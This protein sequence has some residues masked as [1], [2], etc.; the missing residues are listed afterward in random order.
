MKLPGFVFDKGTILGEAISATSAYRVR[1]VNSNFTTE[2]LLKKEYLSPEIHPERGMEIKPLVTVKYNA[3]GL[4][5]AQENYFF[6]LINF[7]FSNEGN[8]V[9]RNKRFPQ[10]EEDWAFIFSKENYFKSPVR[11]T[12]RVGYPGIRWF[13][14]AGKRFLIPVREQ[15]FLSCLRGSTLFFPDSFYSEDKGVP[16]CLY[17]TDDEELIMPKLFRAGISLKKQSDKKGYIFIHGLPS[18]AKWHYGVLK[19]MLGIPRF[20]GDKNQPCYWEHYE[21][22]PVVKL[23]NSMFSKCAPNKESK[24]TSCD[25]KSCNEEN[26]SSVHEKIRQL[27]NRYLYQAIDFFKKAESIKI[28]VSRSKLKGPVRI[29]LECL[30]KIM[31]NPFR[32]KLNPDEIERQEKLILKGYSYDWFS[33]V[34]PSLHLFILTT[35][36]SPIGNSHRENRDSNARR[37]DIENY[38]QLDTGTL[39]NIG[40]CQ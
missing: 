14:C 29:E 11:L 24:S 10:W 23:P 16:R 40:I 8:C 25:E 3:D 5:V 38:I 1:L 30:S 34:S 12:E 32:I 4:H 15:K 18:P 7:F 36:A 6:N 21:G 13:E 2:G 37:R 9:I 27:C 17:K 28:T 22:A 19:H 31:D 20:G 39:S 35:Y 26:F 33:S